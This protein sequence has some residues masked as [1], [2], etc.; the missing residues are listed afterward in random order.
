MLAALL[1]VILC[2]LCEKAVLLWYC[3]IEMNA[4]FDVGCKSE[5]TAVNVQEVYLYM[6]P[7]FPVQKSFTGVRR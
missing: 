6:E 2:V 5:E 7:I 1:P 3:R 4:T